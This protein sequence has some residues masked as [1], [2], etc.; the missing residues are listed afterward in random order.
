MTT[1]YGNVTKPTTTAKHLKQADDKEGEKLREQ[2]R[3]TRPTEF[4][5]DQECEDVGAECEEDVS[6]SN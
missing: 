4:I 2:E 1:K 5:V 3:V 6:E